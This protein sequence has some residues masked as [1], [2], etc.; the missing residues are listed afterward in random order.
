MGELHIIVS[1][2]SKFKLAYACVIPLPHRNLP[3]ENDSRVKP[4]ASD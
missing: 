1:T 4:R 3:R 2:A